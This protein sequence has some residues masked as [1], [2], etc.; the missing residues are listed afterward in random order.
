MCPDASMC[1]AS[2]AS[3]ISVARLYLVLL[4][5]NRSHA[6][7][8]GWPDATRRQR[9]VRFRYMTAASGVHTLSR[10]SAHT[11]VA[12]TGMPRRPVAD[13]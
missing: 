2:P 4:G 7:G 11:T 9:V 12:P 13:G 5:T 1:M 6:I 8:A 10:I 3:R